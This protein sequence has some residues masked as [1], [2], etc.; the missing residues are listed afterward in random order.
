M[1]GRSVSGEMLA[2][3]INTIVDTD[4]FK[5]DFPVGTL[6]TDSRAGEARYIVREGGG[7]RVVLPAEVSLSYQQLLDSETAGTDAGWSAGDY[8][9]WI[10]LC[11]L[12]VAACLLLVRIVSRAKRS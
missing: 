6:V 3:S 1:P 10:G 4:T 7:R 12:V 11:T 8:L 9:R 2:Y 5:F